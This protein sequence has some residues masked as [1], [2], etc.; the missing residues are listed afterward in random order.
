MNKPIRTVSIFCLLLFLALAVNAT[1]LQYY[2]ASALNDRADNGRVATA[3]YSRARGAILV[4]HTPI[5][6]SVKE[7]KD[8]YKYQ[9]TYRDPYMYAPVTG[10]YTFG[11]ETGM[12]RYENSFLSGEDDSL[13]VNR[14]VDLVNGTATKGGNV[15]LT[16]DPAAQ[17]A[18]FDGLSALGPDIEGAVVAIQP[19]TGKILAMVSLPTFDPNKLADHDFKKANAYATRLSKLKSQPLLNRA[20]QTTLAPGSTFKVLTAAAAVEHD[21][22]TSTSVVPA[23]PSYTLP[24]SSNTVHNEVAGCLSKITLTVAM[25]D[26]CNTAF[27][28]LAVKVG[29]TDM[30]QTATAFGFNQQYFDQ[31]PGQ[32]ISRYPAGLDP[33]GTALSGFGQGSVTASPLQM[34]ML[35]AGIAN[36]G[37]VMQPYLVN[38]EQSPTSFE[39]LK[40]GSSH[41]LSQAVSSSTATEVTKMMVATVQ[42][43]TATPAAIPGIQV[44]GKTGTAQSGLKNPDGSEVP[45]Y[46]WFVGFAPAPS[47]KVAVCVMI[48]HINTPT[49]EI[50]GGKLGGPIAKAV[51][52]AVLNSHG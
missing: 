19:D 7:N 20:I 22:L 16:I 6:E 9:R 41:Q 24:Q 21:G 45:P 10:W 15:Q 47:P 23:G 35:T 2:H 32:A 39:T 13:F 52:E 46:A 31:L 43:G 37:V 38:A 29:A 40:P 49:D 11:N 51:M 12:E 25:M 44:A 30:H 26:S 48:Q 3:T 5:A 34:A 50:A 36:H 8:Q 18:A 28:P 42:S 14:L 17:K 27:A 1:Y 4:G 33:P